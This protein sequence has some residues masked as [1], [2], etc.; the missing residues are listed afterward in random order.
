M[1]KRH[2]QPLEP[3]YE[4]SKASLK[5]LDSHNYDKSKC[6]LVFEAYR[7][8]KRDWN[9][10]RSEKR[11]KG[12]PPLTVEEFREKNPSYKYVVNTENS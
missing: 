10:A 7:L 3:C 1:S 5:C 11:R 6:Q 12:L 8:C 4:A 9:A 2:G